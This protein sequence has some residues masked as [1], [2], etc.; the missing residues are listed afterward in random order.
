[1]QDESKQECPG[2]RNQEICRNVQ[3]GSS[4]GENDKYRAYPL[5]PFV[6]HFDLIWYL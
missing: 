5:K 6:V 3:E 2:Y 1:M 4:Y